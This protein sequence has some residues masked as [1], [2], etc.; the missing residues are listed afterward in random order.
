VN[1]SRVRA[2]EQQLLA[3]MQLYGY[4]LVDIPI[5]QPADVFLTRA[6]DLMIERLFTFEHQD[7]MLA[8]RPEFTAAAARHYVQHAAGQI[9]RWQMCGPTFVDDAT[10]DRT[11]QHSLGAELIGVAG[12]AAEAEIISMTIEGVQAVGMSDWRLIMGNV[13]LQW[14]LLARLGLDRRIVRWLLVHRDELAQHGKDHLLS[15]FQATFALSTDPSFAP[16]ETPASTQRMLD[17]MLDS[18]QYG[19]TMGGRTREEIALR[20]LRKHQRAVAR[21]QIEAALDFLAEWIQIEG[22]V[23]SVF[24]KIESWIEEND[25]HGRMLLNQW[26]E[27]VQ[28]IIIAG[29]DPARITLKPNLARNWEYY[30]GLV[31]V[32]QSG[33]G[34]A[35]AGGGRYDELTR[36][37]G[38]S[39]ST[40]AVG[41]A[42][43]I[44]ALLADVHTQMVDPVA[45]TISGPQAVDGAR[46]LRQQDIATVIQSEVS[47][48]TSTGTDFSYQHQIYTILADLITAVKASRA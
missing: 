9:V 2:L 23:A 11:Q 47:D 7:Q 31:F 19:T 21:P 8:L 14:H 3:H 40:P 26:R 42:Y 48:I 15:L 35:V 46:A 10:H 45:I 37:L 36:L 30:T 38:G 43:Y 41:F 4:T 27:T 20:M 33:S 16:D 18:T 1:A 6:G 17:V 22:D 32:L 28:R 12:S 13:A 5:V 44:E 29:L 24:S 25:L 34:E 39:Q